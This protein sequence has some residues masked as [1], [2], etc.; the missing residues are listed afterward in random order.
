MTE[1]TTWLLV[2][3][4]L[5]VAYAI[6]WGVLLGRQDHRAADFFL[7]NR[8]TPAWQY[9]LTA[10][11][12]SVTGWIALGHPSMVFM[13]GLPYAEAGLGM[14]VV[15]LTG[16]LFLKRLWLLSRRHRFATPVALLGAYYQA[17]LLRLLIL[18]MAL[19]FAVPFVGLQL[20]ACGQLLEQL[21]HGLIDRHGASWI[22]AIA[23]YVYVYLGGL[24]V[25]TAVGALQGLLMIAAMIGL[26]CIVYWRLGGGQAFGQALAQYAVQPGVGAPN[27]FEIAGVV[28][29]TAGLGKE[30]PVGGVWTSAMVLSYA[31]ALLGLQAAPSFL[32]LAFSAR[33][34]RGFAPQQVWAG[35]GVIGFI[36]LLFA[37][38]QGLG[39]RLL[40]GAQASVDRLHADTLLALGA[41][42]PW[43][44]A[45]LTMGLIGTVQLT[46]AG[47][48]W[49]TAAMIAQDFCQ[50]YFAPRADD[51]WLRI[52]AR[53]AMALLFIAALSLGTFTPLAQAQLGTLALGFAV[54][55]WPALAGVCWLRWLSRPGITVG[56][57]MGMAGVVL[58]ESLGGSITRFFGFDLP[59]GR[60]PWTIHSAG[61]GLC[62]NVLFCALISLATRK[63]EAREVR[64]RF[65]DELAQI[66][67]LT[68]RRIVM[69]PTIWAL[70][71][72]WFF[73]ALGPGAVLGNDLFSAIGAGNAGTLGVPSLWLWQMVWW[74]LGVF[75]IWWL[76]YKMELATVPRSAGVEGRAAS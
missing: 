52:Y 43:F 67:A 58:T 62:V 29:F 68:P 76:A 59:W 36:A 35:A 73:F 13:D 31:F 34:V 65:H 63:G 44:A 33:D 2:F 21:S 70:T 74:V 49:T 57:C 38:A 9:V 72:L 30:T 4:A 10:T 7:A 22:V 20:S 51:R 8:E 5:L 42:H 61:W 19:V 28:Q 48:V 50:R 15:P 47:C 11:G 64:D 55:L 37:V 69:K 17:E 3:G 66:D 40:A 25:V 14:V 39:G 46:A 6:Y 1:L 23:V 56:L 41:A 45:L 18:L 12:L 60:W 27:L 32:M 26:G 71:L 53:T 16:V 54:Q 24:R 75:L